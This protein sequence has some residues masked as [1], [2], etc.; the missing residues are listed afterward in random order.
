MSRGD[1]GFA[2]CT[3]LTENIVGGKYLWI[4]K[5]KH[6]LYTRTQNDTFSIKRESRDS[7]KPAGQE[8]KLKHPHFSRDG[9]SPCQD[10]KFIS[11]PFCR[12]SSQR[13]RSCPCPSPCL[14]PC[15]LS[16]PSCCRP[17][18]GPLSS[19]RRGSRSCC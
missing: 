15:L 6:L 8:K 9:V 10:V 4:Q 3:F 1:P 13:S 2:R 7:T 14:C 18:P 12:L 17:S 11:F 16:S 19:L 5:P